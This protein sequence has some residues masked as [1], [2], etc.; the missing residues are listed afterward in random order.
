VGEYSDKI[1]LN[2]CQT[3]F[4]DKTF[5]TYEPV[6]LQVGFDLLEKV[7][8]FQCILSYSVYIP[9]NFH[10]TPNLWM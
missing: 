2:I 7:L 10:S 1:F 8:S 9:V 3:N 5:P 4:K 6:S